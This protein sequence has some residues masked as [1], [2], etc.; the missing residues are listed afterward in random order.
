M[1]LVLSVSFVGFD[2]PASASAK[3]TPEEKE[4]T[5]AD[6]QK[7]TEETLQRLYKA[8][9]GA[10]KAIDNSAG[11]AVFS[12]VGIKIF[13][14]GGGRGA[15]MAV[16]KKT[17]KITYMKMVEVQAGLGK[18]VKKF[19]LVWVFEKTDE[20]N[21]FVNLGWELGGQATVAAKNAEKGSAYSGAISISPGVWLY[22]MT[23]KGL[24][25]E[26]SVKGSKYYKN[27]DL[28]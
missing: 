23:D 17:G 10:E 6:I 22:Q 25:A 21:K 27:N 18:G 8:Q 5:R 15:G 12:S 28:N 7:T 19:R 4:S 14:A 26:I 1:A 3:M 24:A 9:P 20:F 16:D 11:Y 2:F 13:V